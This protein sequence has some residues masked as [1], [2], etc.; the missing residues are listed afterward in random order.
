M[1]QIRSLS[2]FS[3]PKGVW[4]VCSFLYIPESCS[5]WEERAESFWDQDCAKGVHRQDG[6]GRKGARKGTS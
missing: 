2:I 6:A 3:F 5:F 1:L 4:E